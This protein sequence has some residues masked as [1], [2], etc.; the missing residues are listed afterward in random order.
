MSTYKKYFFVLGGIYN[1]TFKMKIVI[2]EEERK[3]ILSS[4]SFNDSF[5]KNNLREALDKSN[6]IYTTETG[7]II[8]G[9]LDPDRGKEVK[10]PAGTKVWH[11]Y[12]KQDNKIYIGNTIYY[13]DCGFKGSKDII[14]D[15]DKMNSWRNGPLTT[16]IRETFCNGNKIKTWRELT[17]GGEQKEK[18]S[19]GSLT[20][21]EK[22]KGDLSKDPKCKTKNPYNAFTDAGLNWRV[23]RQKWIDVKCNGTTPCILG[24]AQTNINLRNALCDGNWPLK[25][26]TPQTPEQIQACSTK[27]NA[28]PL[29][30][31]QV[32]PQV[33]GWFNSDDNV[34]YEGTGTAGFASKEECEACKCPKKSPQQQ[35]VTNTATQ[36]SN[37]TTNT[38]PTLKQFPE[39]IFGDKTK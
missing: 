33:Q 6:G 34:C 2:T 26:D 19:P 9:L 3:H 21:T 13:Y 10:I 20:D 36:A 18:D 37:T 27:C 7:Q 22:G 29:Q 16:R 38:A 25:K 5:I 23:E 30:P 28:K 1:K 8:V 11:D 4:H 17:N 24:N 35:V 14:L 31:G 12:N 15:N 39:L 32:G